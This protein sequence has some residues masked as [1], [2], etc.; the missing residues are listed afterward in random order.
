M[1]SPYSCG[2][3]NGTNVR[4][5]R[6]I[7]AAHISVAGAPGRRQHG[8]GGA[9]AQRP[10]RA[11]RLSIH[12]ARRARAAYRRV[13]HFCAAEDAFYTYYAEVSI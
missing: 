9:R 2:A 13:H 6:P 1:I 12:A 11:P 3:R 8:H 4:G 10:R 5:E 7:L